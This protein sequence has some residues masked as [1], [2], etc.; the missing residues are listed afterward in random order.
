MCVE[1]VKPSDDSRSEEE[2]FFYTPSPGQARLTGQVK[3]ETVLRNID[4]KKMTEPSVTPKN[5]YNGGGYVTEVK[6]ENDST[7]KQMTNQAMG[8]A[9]SVTSCF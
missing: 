1:L 6:R 2:E 9:S 3:R 4:N 8:M 7:W 5:V